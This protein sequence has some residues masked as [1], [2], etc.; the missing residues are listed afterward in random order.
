[1]AE[2]CYWHLADV[3]LADQ[4]TALVVYFSHSG[5]WHHEAAYP[6]FR[7]CQQCRGRD[8]YSRYGAL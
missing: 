3:L 8:C 5:S 4:F 2:V 6:P 7:N 1:M